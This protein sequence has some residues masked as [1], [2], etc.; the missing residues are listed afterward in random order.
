MNMRK[1]AASFLPI[2]VSLLVF[3][4][5]L[6]VSSDASPVP[7]PDWV[8]PI[9]SSLPKLQPGVISEVDDIWTILAQNAESH[10]YD[11]K[12][13]AQ[14]QSYSRWFVELQEQA[15]Q[16][17]IWQYLKE[18]TL[19]YAGPQTLN[20]LKHD[21]DLAAWLLPIVRFRVE[22]L[23]RAINDP[24]QR[25]G[26]KDVLGSFEIFDISSYLYHQGEF[27]DIKDLNIIAVEAAK[28]NFKSEFSVGINPSDRLGYHRLL[29]TQIKGM[30]EARNRSDQKSE[31]YWRTLA[32][33]MVSGGVLNQDSLK[34]KPKA[35]YQSEAGKDPKP[36][37]PR[38]PLPDLKTLP[39]FLQP[40]MMW[41]M[42]LMIFA[43]SGGLLVWLFRRPQRAPINGEP[44]GAGRGL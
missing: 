20:R 7:L 9:E 15:D 41:P 18:T 17:L 32:S 25:R 19:P 14:I 43:L 2:G 6:R 21:R 40:W 13:K 35:Q 11:T 30:Q 33:N 28:L 29:Q 8:K 38:K 42:W 34:P 1:L 24:G 22:W 4:A 44:V 16:A 26:A 10:Q 3:T 23:K 12:M 31:P 37:G 5:L 36:L 39:G 27:S